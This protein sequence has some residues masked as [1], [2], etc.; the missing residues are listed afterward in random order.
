MPVERMDFADFVHEVG[1]D[2]S[3]RSQRR[4]VVELS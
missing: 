2:W 3:A 1:T 4:W